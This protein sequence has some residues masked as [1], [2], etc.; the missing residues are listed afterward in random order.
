MKM[1][2]IHTKKMRSIWFVALN[3]NHLKSLSERIYSFTATKLFR[4]AIGYRNR[5][6][7]NS[8]HLCASLNTFHNYIKTEQILHEIR[9]HSLLHHQFNALL[10]FRSLYSNKRYSRALANVAFFVAILFLC[11]VRHGEKM[12]A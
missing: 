12:N 11:A 4:Q 5:C 8:F 7:A 10:F 2:S 1:L 6:T 9:L 3:A